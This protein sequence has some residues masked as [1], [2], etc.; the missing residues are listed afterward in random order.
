YLLACRRAHQYT[1]L[2]V[3]PPSRGHTMI[4]N[5]VRVTL[6]STL[7]AALVLA[8]LPVAGQ[9]KKEEKKQDKK[10]TPIVAPLKGEP[11]TIA[12][13][14]GKNLDGWVG[15]EDLWSVKD[16]VIIGKNTKPVNPSTYLLSKEKFSDFRLTFAT[17]LAESEMHSGVAIWGHYPPNN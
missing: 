5:V 16:G 17:K 6:S 9:D 15:Y 7:L 8:V 11:K 1:R 13:F 3:H 14:N 2:I 10:A 4:R 12:L